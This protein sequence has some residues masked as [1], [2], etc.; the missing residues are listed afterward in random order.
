MK[1]FTGVAL[2][3]KQMLFLSLGLLLAATIRADNLADAANDLCEHVKACSM[4]Q[5]A[6]EEMTPEMRQMVEP[7]LDNMCANMR[8]RVEDVPTGHPLYQPAVSCMRSMTQIGCD[9][10]TSGDSMHTEECKKYEDMARSYAPESQ[11]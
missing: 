11:P 10:M 4:A 1:G 2:T 7:M 3:M 5:I 8:G 9:A 6:Q